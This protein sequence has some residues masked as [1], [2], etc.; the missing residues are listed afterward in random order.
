MTFICKSSG[1]R[2]G[3]LIKFISLRPNGPYTKP[4]EI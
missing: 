2:S 3:T 1:F 4:E